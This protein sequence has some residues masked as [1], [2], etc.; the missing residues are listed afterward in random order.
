MAPLVSLLVLGFAL[1][2]ITSAAGLTLEADK[3]LAD[4]HSI[5]PWVVG[6]R[7]VLHAMPELGYNGMFFYLHARFKYAGSWKRPR[8]P[9]CRCAALVLA[10]A[11]CSELG[12][13]PYYLV[14]EVNTSARIRL[15]LE[16]LGIPYQ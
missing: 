2:T 5:S 1:I 10:T 11:D 12:C 9:L 7:R 15:E 4:A 3:L 6:L 16:R 14:A 8:Q 13:C